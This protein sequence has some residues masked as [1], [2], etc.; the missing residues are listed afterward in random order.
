MFRIA[1]FA[2][3]SRPGVILTEHSEA[4]SKIFKAK[5]L[6]QVRVNDQ[7][8]DLRIWVEEAQ[9]SVEF[10]V[11]GS[12]DEAQ[13][14]AYLDEIVAEVKSAI[15]KFNT[16]DDSDKQRVKR[17][18]VAKACWDRLVHDILNKAPA[19][20]VYFQLAHG[21]EMVIKATE[22]EEVH[23]LTLTTSAWLTN[24]ESLPQ[25]EPLPASTATELAKKSVDWKKETVALIK[26]YL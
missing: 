23:P 20:S 19:S 17:A 22:G 14:T 5:A 18:L 2:A 25:D 12:E 10:T 13:L 7:K 11:W 9:R 15:E 8:A 4:E 21:R 16:L 6:F 3:A 24:I 1:W 26:R